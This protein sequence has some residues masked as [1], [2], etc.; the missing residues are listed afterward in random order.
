[1]TLPF[2]T[3]GEATSKTG[4]SA[5]TVRRIIHSI[6][7]DATH[8]D[9]DAVI[10]S[11]ADA[12]ALKKKGENYTW[13]IREDILD[14]EL[15]SAPSKKEKVKVEGAPDVIAI[16]ERELQ[17][18]NQQIEKQWEVIGSLNERLREGNILMAS[19]QKR[20]ALPEP[21]PVQET[22]VESS[23]VEASM[24]PSK[25]ASKKPMKR[26][27]ET[28]SKVPSTEASMEPSKKGS[29]EAV[30]NAEQKAKKKL[31]SWL[32]QPLGK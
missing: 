2:L 15:G 18:K 26:K 29:V 14:R 8:P 7:R 23:T 9:R 22:V 31:F 27:V 11:P 12:E 25:K 3:I 17:I 24:E 30:K 4:S 28:P 19:L 20:L 6:V 32:W 13:R 21:S 10:P 1:M 16:L 5:S